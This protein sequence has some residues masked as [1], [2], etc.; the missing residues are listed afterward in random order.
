MLHG[1]ESQN[2]PEVIK[3]L[4]EGAY[5]NIRNPAGWTPLMFAA[6]KGDKDAVDAIVKLGAGL[7]I[8]IQ[9]ICIYLYIH[10]LQQDRKRWMDRLTLRC[11]RRLRGDRFNPIEGKCIPGDQNRRRKVRQSYG[12]TL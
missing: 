11:F 1:I 9:N 6:S 5:V 12:E 8:Y 4:Q 10:R 2:I 7:L 3:Y